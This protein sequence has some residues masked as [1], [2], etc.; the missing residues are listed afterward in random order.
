[1]LDDLTHMFVGEGLQAWAHSEGE[2]RIQH[3]PMII[4]NLLKEGI[5][6]PDLFMESLWWPTPVQQAWETQR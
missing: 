5:S 1:M 2:N 3:D 4:W 6:K